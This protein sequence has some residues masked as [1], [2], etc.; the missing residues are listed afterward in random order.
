MSYG[1]AE[2]KH[3]TNVDLA[4]ECFRVPVKNELAPSCLYGSTYNPIESQTLKT[5][6]SMLMVVMTMILGEH[7]ALDNL[8][9]SLHLMK[10]ACVQIP[11][12]LQ[13]FQNSLVSHPREHRTSKL[14]SRLHKALVLKA[15]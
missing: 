11:Q 4:V 3:S 15:R 7:K 1:L 5:W 6:Y 10:V 12:F 13:S 9:I 2:N 8:L 14:A